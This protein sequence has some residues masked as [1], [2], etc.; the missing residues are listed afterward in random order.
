MAQPT[1]TSPRS[2]QADC[3]G[4]A[5]WKGSCEFQV[6]CAMRPRG[7]GSGHSAGDCT[8][9]V[10]QPDR[11]D[12]AARTVQASAADRAR[13]RTRQLLARADD[14][15]V[16]ARLGAQ[17]VERLGA[18]T[19]SPL[20]WPTVK[21]WKPRARR[22]TLAADD[23]ISPGRVAEAGVAREERAL[24]VPARKQRSCES[25]APAT[26]SSAS[27]A[28]ARTSGL[29]SSAEREAHPGERLRRQRGEHVRLVLGGVGGRRAAG[30]RA[31]TPRV[32]ARGEVGGAERVGE[33]EHRVQPH[34][35]VAADARV[36][37]LPRCVAAQER[38]DDARAE[39]PRAGRA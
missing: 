24:P 2:R 17:D 1:I 15:A 3:P 18:P 29:V 25:A 39:L 19:P 34:V 27:A 26:G 20:R 35:P 33:V 4:A 9:V 32:V 16:R 30:R 23:T 38:V 14:D 11:V 37:R 22:A 6:Q 36:R 13:G 10:A 8:R 5:P 21:W 31:V 12:L 7:R 28:S